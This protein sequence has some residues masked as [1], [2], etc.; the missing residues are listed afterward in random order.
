MTNF[1]LQQASNLKNTCGNFKRLIGRSFNDP[2][3]QAEI[4]HNNVE[5]VA[6]RDGGVGYKVSFRFQTQFCVP[7]SFVS[8]V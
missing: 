6:T 3:V 5:T 1:S 2:E 4:K 7:L 8:F